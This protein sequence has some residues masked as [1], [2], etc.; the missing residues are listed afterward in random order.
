MKF[1]NMVDSEGNILTVNASSFRFAT[2]Q[3]RIQG[4]NRLRHTMLS[5]L[6][7]FSPDDYSFD[8]AFQPFGF[9]DYLLW[10][11]K[12]RFE[13]DSPL[14]KQSQRAIRDPDFQYKDAEQESIFKSVHSAYEK[15]K[16]NWYLV[17]REGIHLTR[18]MYD[19]NYVD[20][21]L[22]PPVPIHTFVQMTDENTIS[23]VELHLEELSDKLM[24]R[25]AGND[26][27]N[28]KCFVQHAFTRQDG[29]QFDGY[30]MAGLKQYKELLRGRDAHS[31]LKTTALFYLN[32]CRFPEGVYEMYQTLKKQVNQKSPNSPAI[33]NY[34]GN[35]VNV[36]MG[37][38]RTVIFI[39]KHPI[40]ENAVYMI[41]GIRFEKPEELAAYIK[42]G[43]C[44]ETPPLWWDEVKCLNKNSKGETRHER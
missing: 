42:S 7:P 36:C 19:M 26:Y 38:K 28:P 4:V 39:C 5:A 24:Y 12:V 31:N 41:N 3:D 40:H 20:A 25:S 1:T 44:F 16:T 30:V 13:G 33:T 35:C 27:H 22:I 11:T 6:S 10:F 21:E 37:E 29:D 9:D 34:R 15:G 43:K 2:Q 32:D 14:V 17:Y 23:E 18:N 8:W